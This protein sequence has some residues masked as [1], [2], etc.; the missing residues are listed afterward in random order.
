M[1]SQETASSYKPIVI[2]EL[3]AEKNPTLAR[4]IPGFVYSMLNRLL[5]IGEINEII[6]RFGNLKG[7][8]FL[9]AVFNYFQVQFEFRGVENLPKEGR[10]IFASNHPLGGFDGMILHYGVDKYVGKSLFLVRDELT[11]IPQLK[12]LFVPIN[13]HGGQRQSANQIHEAYSSA[14]Q[15]LIFPS[16]MASRKIKGKI[17]D[18]KW[19]KH[20]IQKSIEYQRDVI[21]VHIQ[22]RNSGFFYWLSNFR[23]L[24]GIKFN[25]EMFLLPDEMFK[26]RGKTFIITFG[27]PI[28]CR[29]FDHTKNASDWA[30]EVRKIV[31]QLPILFKK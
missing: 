10:Y 5:H 16:G 24:I 8:E 2:K 13:K 28:P 27:K 3:I 18:L 12:E 1:D 26:Q 9:S 11:K 30:D 19:Q 29:T 21:P 22:G 14:N 17:T 20:F 25:I 7:I 31:Y 6:Y 15:V 23:Q 4:R